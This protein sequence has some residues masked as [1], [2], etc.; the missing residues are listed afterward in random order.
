D[1]D[2]DDEEEERR[3]PRDFRKRLKEGTGAASS[4]RS[5]S[6]EGEGD[7]EDAAEGVPVSDGAYRNK[8]RVLVFSSRGITSRYRHLMEDLRRLLP[9]HKKDA[10]LD[11]G[12]NESLAAAVNAICEMKSCNGCVFLECR[13]KQDLFLWI[14]RTPHGPSAKFQVLNVHTM[15]ELKLTGNCML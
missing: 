12:K 8:Q 10:K 1:K 7:R 6:G 5:A 9:H 11:V 15:D 14:G 3:D 4:G 2:D 13:K